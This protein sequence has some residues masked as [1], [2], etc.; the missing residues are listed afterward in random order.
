MCSGASGWAYRRRTH[1][2]SLALELGS[3]FAIGA[4]LG[5]ALAWVAVEIVNAHLNPL[6]DLPPAEL[7]EVPWIALGTG[8][9]VAFG[10]WL[11]V[12]VWAQHVREQESSPQ[13]LLR[14]DD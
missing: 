10:A 7:V 14:F 4:V 13:S 1:A 11:L 5:A 8:V 2:F 9:L 6:P 12:T 3:L